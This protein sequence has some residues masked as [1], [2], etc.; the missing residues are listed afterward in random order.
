V[1]AAAIGRLREAASVVA[2]VETRGER[3][4]S[5]RI[6]EAI[7][8]EPVDVV[9]AAGG[10]GT[11]NLALAA[12]L[13]AANGARPALALL[14]LGTGNNAARS[15]GLRSLRREGDVASALA[16]D[17]IAKGARRAIDVGIVNQRPFLGSFS[18]GLD[19][20]ILERRNR[21]HRRLGPAGART[22]YGLYLA[23]FAISIVAARPLRNARLVLDGVSETA[24]IY[25]AVVANA[26]VYAGPLRFDGANDCADGMLD[27]HAVV[28]APGYVSEFSRAWLRYLRC[29]RGSAVSPSPLLRRAHEIEIELDLAVTAQVDGE[30]LGAASR[31]RLSLLPRAIRVCIPPVTTP[32]G[33]VRSR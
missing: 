31:Y 4:D 17:A 5:Q 20:E 1:A 15:F 25:N 29:L 19:A 14:P 7:E 22:G 27:L 18:V 21:I 23:S 30:E 13:Q 16:V 24:A 8:Q 32:G 9:A 28:S 2:V 33:S 12:M 26:A 6:A 3:E 10:D 11:A